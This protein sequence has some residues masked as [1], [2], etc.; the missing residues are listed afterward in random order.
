MS[1]QLCREEERGISVHI[2]HL[3]CGVVLFVCV[4]KAPRF[5]CLTRNSKQP[6][7]RH[8]NT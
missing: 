2:L 7:H 1:R 3:S 4:S 6:H 8:Q 5:V